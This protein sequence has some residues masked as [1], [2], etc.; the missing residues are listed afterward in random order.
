MRGLSLVL[1]AVLA[2]GCSRPPI[3]N[4]D[5]HYD[6][7]YERFHGQGR[8]TDRL[9]ITTEF[10]PL[11]SLAQRGS[12]VVYAVHPNL[13]PLFIDRLSESIKASRVDRISLRSTS[14]ADIS[15]W[16][17]RVRGDGLNISVEIFDLR[18]D[19][20]P[21]AQWNDSEFASLRSFVSDLRLMAELY[22]IPF[23]ESTKL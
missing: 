3:L 20:D 14:Y 5:G 15:T 6:I 11:D 1:F 8:V 18:D 17:L 9:H 4:P 7:V 12:Q 2:V 16:R 19:K 22:A 10:D 23:E 21:N 13:K